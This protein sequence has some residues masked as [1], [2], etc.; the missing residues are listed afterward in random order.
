MPE[1]AVL[2]QQTAVD[3]SE[4][5]RLLATVHVDGRYAPGRQLTAKD[6][7]TRAL[8]NLAIEGHR[9]VRIEPDARNNWSGGASR[10]RHLCVELVWACGVEADT[11]P[12]L[13]VGPT[14]RPIAAGSP[15][16]LFT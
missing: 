8:V 12:A 6:G 2:G 15:S 9:C 3:L 16:H 10:H 4:M 13:T 5:P 14:R 1:H 7:G 11:R